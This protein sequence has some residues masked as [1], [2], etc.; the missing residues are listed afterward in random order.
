[1]SSNSVLALTAQTMPFNERVITALFEKAVPAIVRVSKKRLQNAHADCKYVMERY[2]LARKRLRV[3]LN[4]ATAALAHRLDRF[5]RMAMGKWLAFLSTREIDPADVDDLL[6]E[7]F[8]RWLQDQGLNDVDACFRRNINAWNKATRLD[9]WPKKPLILPRKRIPSCLPWPAFPDTLRTEV[10]AFFA[11][12]KGVVGMFADGAAATPLAATTVTGQEECLR[13]AASALVRSGLQPHDLR[14]LRDLC[15]PD[16]FKRALDQMARDKGFIGG[17]ASLS[18]GQVADVLAKIAKYANVLAPEE[19]DMVLDDR[20]K[21]RA[22]VKR[23]MRDREDRDQKLLDDLDNPDVV[24]ALLTLARRTVDGVLKSRAR[25]YRDAIR[26][27]LALALEIWLSAPIRLGNMRHL[28]LDKHFF[29]VTFGG[30]EHVVL[31][32]PATEVKNGKTIEHL[33][34]GDAVKLLHLYIE[35]FLPML[36][37]NNPSPWLFPGRQGRPKAPQVFRAQTSKFVREG[38]GLRFHPH[39]IRKITAKL[40]LDQDPG[41]IE[42]VRRSLGDTLE[43]ARSVYAPRVHRESQRTY[44]D[45]LEA[46][47]LEAFAP[48]ARPRSKREKSG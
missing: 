9:G 40:Y 21:V 25:S 14:G 41:G 3:T 31:R 12:G 15:A 19:I 6:T 42:I 30:D 32:I 29:R 11:R 10:D 8:R 34:H 44:M 35:R 7:Q 23:Y 38:T 24:D 16:R 5:Q 4:P 20:R 27:Q 13:W 17:A 33:L 43:I 48:L 46:R 2:G 45:A 39:A 18:I 37:R 28:R 47:R 26:V 36:T 1:M 22:A